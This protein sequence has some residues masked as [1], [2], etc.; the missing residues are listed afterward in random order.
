VCSPHLS[1]RQVIYEDRYQ[2]IYKVTADFGHF[3]KEY[4][5]RDSG[6]RAGVVVM[7]GESV[8]LVRQY[9]LLINGL[10]WEIPGGKVDD[11]ETPE[12]AAIRECLEET[13]ILCRNPK[14][15][16]NYHL[17]LEIIHNP[18]HLFY[19]DQYVEQTE[20]SFNAQEV[21]QRLWV[22]LVRCIDMIFERQIVDSFTIIALLSYQTLVGR[23]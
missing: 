15:L 2:R 4:F 3:K 6:E 11:G 20:T 9:R 10:S 7:Q 8:L 23:S 21:V 12:E 13:G 14:P 19:T 5:V 17:G 16:L 18:S 22:P 1:P